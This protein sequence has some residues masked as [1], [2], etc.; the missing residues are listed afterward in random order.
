MGLSALSFG[1][2][3]GAQPGKKPAAATLD[4]RALE[5]FNEGK[6]LMERQDYAAA[7]SKFEESLRVQRGIGT[8]YKLGEC[9][10]KLGKIA[11]AW[12]TF[13]DVAAAADEAGQP[14]RAR[15][16]R[17]KVQALG[18]KLSKLR[19]VV[20]AEA[21]ARDIDVQKDGI[22]VSRV[23]WGKEI[24]IDPGPHTV[25]A[26][27]PGRSPWTKTLDIKGPAE[28]LTVEVP[29]LKSAQASITTSGVGGS[30]KDTAAPPPGKRSLVPALALGGL[31]VAG[32]GAGVT[33]F[34]VS[35]SKI[36]E[37]EAIANEIATAGGTCIEPSQHPR[38]GDL[39]SVT[40]TVRTLDGLAVGAGVIG[41]LAAGG[42]LVYLLLPG[43]EGRPSGSAVRLAPVASPRGGGLVAV[44]SF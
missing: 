14:D 1:G 17:E 2:A 33:M 35:S 27:A 3:A 40:S 5:L 15:A 18:P 31:A 10:E 16:A 8:L 22:S 42:T 4:P 11:S 36:T 6:A 38:C 44:G 23:L 24:P 28:A 19:I 7:S 37:G 21:D 26:T 41:I 34:L 13:L 20:L 25:T 29:A 43:L 9:Q 39:S 30:A 12:S 32:L